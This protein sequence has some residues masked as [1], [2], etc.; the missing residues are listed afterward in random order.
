MAL[1]KTQEAVLA[2]VRDRAAAGVPAPSYREISK[3]F[4]WSSPTA[5]KS[6]MKALIRKGMLLPPVP[7][8]A[9]GTTLARPIVYQVDL[10]EGLAPRRAVTQIEVPT[11]ML[12]EQ[13]VA[14]AFQ[15]QD[16]SLASLGILEDDLVLVGPP[17]A[18]AEPRLAVVASR[19]KPIVVR[20]GEARGRKVHGVVVTLVRSYVAASM[21]A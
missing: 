20:P 6:H 14:F 3:H 7:G 18:P 12:A 4:G 17:D 11:Y 13:G 1:T 5:A 9:R 16:S 21:S 10:I 2:F 8:A 19:G 15:V